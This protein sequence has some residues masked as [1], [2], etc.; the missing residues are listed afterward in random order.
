VTDD[1]RALL[2]AVVADPA[3]DTVRLAYADCIEE[4]GNPVRAAFIRLQ[5][6]AE[7]LHP[8]S[9]ARLALEQQAEALFAE[10]WIDWWAEVCTEVGL[11]TPAPKPATRLGSLARRAG[12]ATPG[13][14]PY[15]ANGI[16]VAPRGAWFGG[17]GRL[18]GWS[19]CAFRRGFPDS[20]LVRAYVG[21]FTG[22]R[23]HHPFLSRWPAASPID[24]LSATVP[25]VWMW[26]DAPH[27][28]RL[29]TLSLIDYDPEVL[30]AIL[31]S[32][33][34]GRLEDL[35]LFRGEYIAEGAIVEEFANQTADAVALLRDRQ[36]KRLSLQVWT[37]AA[38]SAVGGAA[39]LASLTALDV[40][41][42]PDVSD[43][44]EGA[45]WR[46]SRLVRSPH[47][48]GLKELT[49]SGWP[50]RGWP[51]A[52]R[53]HIACTPATWAEL[54]K[55]TINADLGVA[56][57]DPHPAALLEGTT[58]PALEELRVRAIYL[59]RQA[60]DHL[61]RSPL[62]KQLR[63]FAFDAYGVDSVSDADLRRLPEMFDLD[64]LETF[65]F[66][67]NRDSPGLDELKRQLGDRLRMR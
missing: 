30:P 20:I 56:D 58:F 62:L 15:R 8:D 40:D 67:P 32:P 52:P 39:H 46:L 23:N 11:P 55:L 43:D 45:T 4:H 1:A 2:A 28:D 34:L 3:D 60:I 24:A 38:A 51:A 25:S 47:L 48:A 17:G 27:L 65:R 18:S 54:R 21:I 6:E 41:I 64:R 7:R 22:P 42:L 5:V 13:G 36:L 57:L 66:N 59:D 50:A 35:T 10:H 49:V 33:R 19:G 44:Y 26:L 29:R 12:L 9:N 53:S 61:V 63:H 16:E 37:D 14:D 31:G